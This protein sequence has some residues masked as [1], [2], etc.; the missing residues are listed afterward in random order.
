LNYAKDGR[1]GSQKL[2]LKFVRV[3]EGSTLNNSRISLLT[4]SRSTYLAYALHSLSDK[5][6]LGGAKESVISR[7]FSI[8]SSTFFV[9]FFFCVK[10]YFRPLINFIRSFIILVIIFIAKIC[11]MY[12]IFGLR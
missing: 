10:I 7:V 3:R 6:A 9:I 12:K 2:T 8:Y 4:S 5:Q 1:I 11:Q